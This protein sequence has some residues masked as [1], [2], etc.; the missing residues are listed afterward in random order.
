MKG[1]VTALLLA[2]PSLACAEGLPGQEYSFLSSFIQMIAALSVVIGLILITR[3]FSGK[4]IKSGVANRFGTHIRLLE[5]RAISPKK[6]L[7]LVEVGGEYLLLASTENRLSLLKQVHVYEEIEVLDD[8][9]S[10]R[11]ELFRLFRRDAGKRR[12]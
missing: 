3:H 9:V 11:P 12:S 6:S 8:D 7:V 10:V 1:A 5:T 4:L 2:L